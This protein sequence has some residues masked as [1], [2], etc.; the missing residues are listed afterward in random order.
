MSS[1]VSLVS[2]FG[3]IAIVFSFIVIAHISYY[4]V[5]GSTAA[6]CALHG[7]K[8]HFHLTSFISFIGLTF[9]SIVH[10]QQVLTGLPSQG[11]LAVG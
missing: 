11:A 9:R 7:H 8:V 5:R 1:V 2:I 6:V 4:I 10:S 3:Y